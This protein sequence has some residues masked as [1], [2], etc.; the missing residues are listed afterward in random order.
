MAPNQL[1]RTPIFRPARHAV[2]HAVIVIPQ[3]LVEIGCH[4]DI[5]SELIADLVVCAAKVGV[6]RFDRGIGAYAE[7]VGADWKAEPEPVAA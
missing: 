5:D 3:S 6:L 2:R 7:Y 4:A 1:P